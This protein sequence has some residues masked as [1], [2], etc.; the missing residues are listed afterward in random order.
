MIKDICPSCN[1]T[2]SVVGEAYTAS[3]HDGV[4]RLEQA[5]ESCDDCHATG[6]LHF[7]LKEV[8]ILSFSGIDHSDH[9]DY[10][11]AFIEEALYKGKEMT[12]GQ[13]EILQDIYDEFVYDKL[14]EYIF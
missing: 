4:L 5:L 11:D 1:G 7:D 13:L 10:C 14:M 12:E 8:E 2:G 6:K 9:P 3:T